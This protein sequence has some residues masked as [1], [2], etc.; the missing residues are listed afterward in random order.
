MSHWGQSFF[1]YSE[2]SSLFC[3]QTT[4]L[5]I[6][7]MFKESL[8]CSCFVNS[9][10]YCTGKLA[11]LWIHFYKEINLLVSYLQLHVSYIVLS[12]CQCFPFLQMYNVLCSTVASPV[13]GIVL[14]YILYY[15]CV[16]IFSCN[17]LFLSDM[18]KYSYHVALLCTI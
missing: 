18:R 5:Q 4:P 3:W 13:T 15:L 6:M 2:L 8:S 1:D 17:V 16:S 12:H 9:N 14:K 10:A 7:Q 11:P